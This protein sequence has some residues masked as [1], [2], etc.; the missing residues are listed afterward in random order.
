MK[1]M[2]L[3]INPNAGKRKGKKHLAEIISVFN[4]ADYQVE[5]Y[6]TACQGDGEKAVENRASEMDLVVCCGGDGTFNETVSGLMKSGCNTPV[7]YIPA[8]STNDFA[9]TLGLNKKPIK[10]AKQIVNGSAMAVDVGKF[11]DRYFT[12]VASFGAFTHASY[13][14]SQSVKNALG[15]TAYLLKGVTELS[16]IK[17]VRVRMEIDDAIIEDDFLFGAICN[18]TSVGGVLKLDPKQVD[19]SDGRFE[20]MLI[21]APRSVGE[22][23]QCIRA[24]RKKKY[25]CKM[26]TFRSAEKV[27][28]IAPETMA[29]TLDG[30]KAEGQSRIEVKNLQHAIKLVK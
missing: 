18:S 11:A 12:Y 23:T 9:K 21:R 29:W 8:G 5:V 1:K 13:A 3:V 2:L 14:T 27:T 20:V 6:M 28:V 16:K 15:H 4:Q 22:L 26:I 19:M 24:L 17:K 10:A 30:E 7:G 25:N